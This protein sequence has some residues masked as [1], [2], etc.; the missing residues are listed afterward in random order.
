MSNGVPVV[1]GKVKAANESDEF[2]KMTEEELTQLFAGL[3]D[4]D[5]GNGFDDPNKPTIINDTN[6]ANVTPIPTADIQKMTEEE[7]LKLFGCGSDVQNKGN[8]HDP[9]NP[10]GKAA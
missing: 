5:E 1:D 10:N 9:S 6:A 7:L 3:G 2:Q 8:G 4:D